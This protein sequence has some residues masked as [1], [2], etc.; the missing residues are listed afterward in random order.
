[1]GKGRGKGQFLG[2]SYFW[3]EVLGLLSYEGAI[4][5]PNLSSSCE[6][7]CKYY[8]RTGIQYL[9][10]ICEYG[11][12]IVVILMT[13]PRRLAQH[14]K[15]D[16]YC[17]MALLFLK[18]GLAGPLYAL[19][20]IIT[21]RGRIGQTNSWTLYHIKAITLVTNCMLTKM[22]NCLFTELYMFEQQMATV[23]RFWAML[24]CL[25]KQSS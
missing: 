12:F 6:T 5:I 16:A 21:I 2:I 25:L 9:S 18:E 11:V 15:E 4:F 17:R 19:L 3:I 1:M 20:Q 7:V 13:F 24:L 22:R 23:G 10:T 14:I 8:C